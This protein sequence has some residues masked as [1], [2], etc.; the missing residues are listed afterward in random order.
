M[1]LMETSLPINKDKADASFAA[2]MCIG[3]GACVAACKNSSAMLF[4]S[5][6]GFSFGIVTTRR[7]RKTFTCYKYD[8]SNG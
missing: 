5:A 8:C 1:L 6:K 7:T 3:C 2:A 4:M